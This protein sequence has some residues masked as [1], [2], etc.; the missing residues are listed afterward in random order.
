MAFKQHQIPVGKTYSSPYCRCLDTA[1]NIFGKAET[2][3]ALHFALHLPKSKR[4][5]SAKQ[6][7][8][9]LA[10]PPKAGTNTAMVSH[11]GNLKEAVNIWPKKEGEAHIFKPEGND[12]FSYVGMMSPDAWTK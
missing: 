8:V 3:D 10:T 6:L 5:V 9:M 2:S 1:K 7:R 4:G 11:T 12:T